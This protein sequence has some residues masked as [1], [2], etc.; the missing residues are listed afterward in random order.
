MKSIFLTG[1]HCRLGLRILSC[2]LS[3]LLTVDEIITLNTCI[4]FLTKW[5][6]QH[7]F[8][9]HVFFD[10]IIYERHLPIFAYRYI[11]FHNYERV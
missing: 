9:R 7:I 2:Y 3:G 5:D 11:A 8:L 6:H 4:F 10:L 1:S